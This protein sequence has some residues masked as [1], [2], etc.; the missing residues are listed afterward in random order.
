M[1]VRGGT[2]ARRTKNHP[3]PI[4]TPAAWT[5]SILFWGSCTSAGLVHGH[6][7]GLQSR[8]VRPVQMSHVQRI[9]DEGVCGFVQS[10]AKIHCYYNAPALCRRSVF[11]GFSGTGPKCHAV[12]SHVPELSLGWVQRRD[13]R[14]NP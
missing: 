5:Q 14:T 12:L 6:G 8:Y 11:V 1:V 9:T 2:R 13:A 10:Y 3:L 7:H 4:G